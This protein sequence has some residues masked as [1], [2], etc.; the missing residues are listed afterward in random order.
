[1][2]NN[3]EQIEELGFD[4]EVETLSLDDEVSNKIDEMLDFFEPSMSIK[5]DNSNEL[6]NLLNNKSIEEKTEI[7]SP[8][9]KLDV[10]VPSIKDFNI[11]SEK[12]RKIVKKSML[13]VI[14]IMLLCFEV[15]ITKTGSVLNDL[16]VYASDNEPIK[17]MQNNKYGYI[18]YNGNKLVNPK[19]IYG[20]DFIKGYAIVKNSSNLP[21]VINRGGKEIIKDDEYFSLYRAGNDIIASKS[22]KKGLKYGILDSNLKIKTKFTY[23]KISYLGDCY[24]YVKGNEVGLI[25][26]DGK[27]V[28]N[29]KLTD[30]ISKDISV[31]ISNVSSD[32]YERYAVVKVNSSSQV[33]NINDG[34]IVMS[35]TL[36]E[37]TAED[38]NVF[39]ETSK[40]GVK[41]YFYVQNNKVLLESDNYIDLDMKSVKTGVLKALTKNHTYEYISTKTLEQFKKNLND[42]EVF[43]GDNVFMYVDYNFKKNISIINMVKDGEVF[44]TLEG[45]FKVYKEFVNGIAIISFSDNTYGYLNEEGKFISDM[46]FIEA[47]TFDSY[48]DAI[49]KTT[50]GYGVINKQ[51]K[52]IIDFNNQEIKMASDK[53]KLKSLN[54]TNI[55]Y[56]VRKDNKYALYK[57][58]GKR[59]DKI[60][61]NNVSF[62]NDY[63]ILIIETDANDL[64]LM[65]KEKASINLTSANTDYK[66]YDNYIIVKNE[67]Y[68]YKGKSIY[69]DYNIKES[70]A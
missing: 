45:D 27:N 22:S 17:I 62:D 7:I 43:Y 16:K 30:E 64:I 2:S 44:K 15:F 12:T 25:N 36:N 9:E 33:V 68:N 20:E 48:G 63:P 4:D 31:N 70:G 40:T 37:I 42:V 49:A 6:D 5:E 11:K 13:Y 66:A 67:Y 50:N 8:N 23:D 10:Y 53:V 56:A 39:Y 54:S 47:N 59:Y 19:Y 57:S 52:V 3:I 60:Y 55:Y 41:T 58:N 51:G 65:P 28:F 46:H 26:N 1:M 35:P 32:D 21:L 24:S 14:I 61:Y 18:D 38:N 29:Y 34:S 69:I